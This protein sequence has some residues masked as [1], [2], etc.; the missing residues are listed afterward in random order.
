VID[1]LS[2]ALEVQRFCQEQRWNFCFIGGIAVQRWGEPRITR[3]VDVTILAAFGQEA[4]FADALLA[5]FTPRLK[6]AREFAEAH[7]VLLIESPEHV[8]IDITFAGLP[9]GARV[10]DRATGYQFG[11][12]SNLLTCSAEDL[13]VMKLFANR[14]LDVRDAEG[15]ALRQRGR[16]D[17][18][19]IEEELAPLAEV[20]DDPSILAVLQRIRNL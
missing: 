18:V 13:I 3:N 4:Q 19:L 15:I 14:P 11:H 2:V 6:D 20:K 8:G 9:Y 5:R 1:L 16:L 7:R 10:V 12:Q 17:W